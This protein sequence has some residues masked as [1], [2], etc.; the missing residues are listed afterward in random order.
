MGESLRRDDTKGF[1]K[2]G[3]RDRGKAY[4]GMMTEAF[5]KD[6]LK[7]TSRLM[8]RAFTWK[9]PRYGK[10]SQGKHRWDFITDSFLSFFLLQRFEIIIS[11]GHRRQPPLTYKS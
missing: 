2:D 7:L 9:K 5:N 3:H 4:I 6:R 8:K 11:G 10:L 1:Y